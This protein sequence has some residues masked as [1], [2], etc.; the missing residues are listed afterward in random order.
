MIRNNWID[1]TTPITPTTPVWPGDPVAE[2]TP[3]LRFSNGDGCNLSALSAGLHTGTH[4]DA[5]LHFIPEGNDITML[6]LNKMIGDVQ[7]LDATETGSIYTEWIQQN[8][9]PATRRILFKTLSIGET[10]TGSGN[11]KALDPAAAKLLLEKEVCFCGID[12]LSIATEDTLEETHKILLNHQVIIAEHLNLTSITAGVYE[13]IC[14]PIM[15]P[16]A[17]AAPA[18]VILRQ[19]R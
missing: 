4:L 19:K 8:I 15:I 10:P 9:H 13:M 1:I 6:D 11:F 5:P 14:L 17:E 7:V 18:R 12:G 2:L 3:I 16:G